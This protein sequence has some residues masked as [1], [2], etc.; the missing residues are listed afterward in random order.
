MPSLLTGELHERERRADTAGDEP[1]L[2]LPRGQDQTDA[3][4]DAREGTSSLG[5]GLSGLGFNALNLN[6]T[7]IQLNGEGSS[8]AHNSQ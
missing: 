2:V 3:W 4:E 5:L 8:E 1:V 7:L 6:P